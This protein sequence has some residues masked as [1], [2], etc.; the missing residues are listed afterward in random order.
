M[1][2][3]VYMLRC[4]DGSI[5]TGHSDDLELRLAAHQMRTFSGYTESRLPVRLIFHEEFPTRHEAFARERQIKGWS[6][7]KKLA[8]ASGDW[9]AVQR[10]SAAHGSTGSP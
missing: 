1:G 5:Y 3:Y 2:F 8:L 9:E 10:L 7:R 4:A 6:R